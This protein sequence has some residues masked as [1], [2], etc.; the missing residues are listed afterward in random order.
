MTDT[1][2]FVTPPLGLGP[3]TDF[4]LDH[5]ADSATLFSLQALTD[6]DLR[7][8]VINPG[9][10]VDD[11]KPVISGAQAEALGIADADDAVLFVIARLAEDGIGV[12]LLAPI[13]VNRH[14]GAAAQLILEGQG[15]P[16]RHLLP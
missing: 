15:Y 9:D 13:V 2:T 1:V 4:E 3:H 6:P 14:T 12:N 10:I 16:V 5:V 7:L 11:Y 8:F